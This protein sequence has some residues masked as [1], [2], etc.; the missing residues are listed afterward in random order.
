MSEVRDSG[1][2][3]SDPLVS[4][5]FRLDLDGTPAAFFTEVSGLGS[6][7]EVMEQ[8]VNDG[9]GHQV[10]LKVPGREKWE[11]ISLKRGITRDMELWDWREIVMQGD[12]KAARRNG[13]ITM[14]DSQGTPVA[15]WDF[16]NAWPSKVTG[17]SL[18]IDSND[19]GIEEITIVHEGIRRIR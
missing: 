12:V 18:K 2:L 4:F 5:A 15:Q 7:T 14:M 1:V 16:T 8:I 3:R 9:S 19:L 11:D 6:E 17:P 13:T 10:I